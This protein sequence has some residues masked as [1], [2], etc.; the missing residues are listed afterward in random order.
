MLDEEI[1]AIKARHEPIDP[2]DFRQP[3]VPDE[4]NAVHFILKLSTISS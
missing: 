4:Q 1:A 3:P 2:E